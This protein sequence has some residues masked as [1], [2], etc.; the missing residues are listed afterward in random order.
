MFIR[1]SPGCSPNVAWS[2][3]GLMA[4]GDMRLMAQENRMEGRKIEVSLY[5]AELRHW[6]K[7]E[8]YNICWTWTSHY[9]TSLRTTRHFRQCG[10]FFILGDN[11]LE[12]FEILV[13]F[14]VLE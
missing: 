6:Q 2:I 9:Q 4:C 14:L 5:C 3:S 8:N 11:Y 13:G 10:T 1:F 7:T 12:N